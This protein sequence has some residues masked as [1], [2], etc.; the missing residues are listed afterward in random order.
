MTEKR[1]ICSMFARMPDTV[2][3]DFPRRSAAVW[4]DSGEAGQLV[5]GDRGSRPRL[6]LPGGRPPVGR[7]CPASLTSPSAEAAGGVKGSPTGPS[8][9]S[10]EAVPLTPSCRSGASRVPAAP[11]DLH[12]ALVRLRSRYGRTERERAPVR[13]AGVV[14]GASGR[15][16]GLAMSGCGGVRS[17]TFSAPRTRARFVVNVGPAAVPV[18]AAR[19]GGR[20]RR[21]E[22]MPGDPELDGRDNRG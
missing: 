12:L 1:S 5:G 7:A 10:C 20:T 2:C 6:A 14:R 22:T 19:D 8:A 4:G 9:A 3:R 17:A 13:R 11:E 16:A 18:A 15:A 21:R